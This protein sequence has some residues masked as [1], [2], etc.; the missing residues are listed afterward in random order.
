MN[1]YQLFLKI[2]MRDASQFVPEYREK[3]APRYRQMLPDSGKAKYRR[4]LNYVKQKYYMITRSSWRVCHKSSFKERGRGQLC[5]L[6]FWW[7][8]WWWWWWWWSW[9]WCAD[10]KDNPSGKQQG[11]C[12]DD[13][14]SGSG[15]DSNDLSQRFS[16]FF[17]VG[18][19]FISQ[20]VLRTTL[21]LGLSNSL[22]LP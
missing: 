14:S 16:N 11:L 1:A 20:N 22:G 6:R 21:P 13:S 12:F 19:T 18:T 4:R 7:S 10:S 17:Q 8:W 5:R 15:S 9:W 2:F 3:E